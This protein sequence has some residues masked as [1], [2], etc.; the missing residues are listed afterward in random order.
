MNKVIYY[1]TIYWKAFP[2]KERPSEVET[3]SISYSKGNAPKDRYDH[4]D[5][6]MDYL[7]DTNPN[8]FKPV[9]NF[10]I[11]KTTTEQQETK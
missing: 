8:P 4:H 3:F 11:I 1:Y 9:P 5:A 6:V 2:T 7:I 10:I